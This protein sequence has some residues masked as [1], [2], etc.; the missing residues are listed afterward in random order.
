M[1]SCAGVYEHLAIERRGEVTVVR[2]DR[3]PANALDPVLLSEGARCVEELAAEPADGPAG[4]GERELRR[5][6]ARLES[7]ERELALM[8]QGLDAER[9]ALLD[10]ER[11][12][13]RREIAEVRQSF[14]PPLAPPS[15]SEGLAS[16]VRERSRE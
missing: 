15:F 11:A 8:R 1:R 9:N 13:R 10:R 6:E 7:R 14:E 5:L 12:L 4:E 3:P 16:F 2:I